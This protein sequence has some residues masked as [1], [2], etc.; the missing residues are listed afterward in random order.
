[1]LRKPLEPGETLG[2]VAVGLQVAQLGCCVFNTIILDKC[3]ENKEF[4]FISVALLVY[5]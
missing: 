1:M 4:Y 3:K 5:I 2:K